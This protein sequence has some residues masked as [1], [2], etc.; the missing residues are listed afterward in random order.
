MKE[1][2]YGEDDKQALFSYLYLSI[3]SDVISKLTEILGINLYIFQTISYLL[4]VSAVSLLLAPVCLLLLAH[5]CNICSSWPSPRLHWFPQIWWLS[6]QEQSALIVSK[7]AQRFICNQAFLYDI[8]LQSS[9]N[10]LGLTK[11]L[12]NSIKPAL[13]SLEKA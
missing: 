1:K 6:V 7:G 11:P 13:R 12:N 2:I 8:F 4:S 3:F 5:L 10:W 9:I